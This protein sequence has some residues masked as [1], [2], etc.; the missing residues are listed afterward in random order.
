MEIPASEQTTGTLLRRARRFLLQAWLEGNFQ[1]HRRFR[2]PVNVLGRRNG[3]RNIG[4]RAPEG[5][6]RRGV[7]FAPGLALEGGDS[8]VHHFDEVHLMLLLRAPEVNFP[9]VASERMP[10][11]ALGEEQIFP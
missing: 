8:A 11:Q 9:S 6:E 4:V 2:L 3:H 1:T 5:L 7:A 10:L